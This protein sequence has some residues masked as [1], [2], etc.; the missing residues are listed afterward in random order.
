MKLTSFIA[1]LATGVAVGLLLAPKKGEELRKDLTDKTQDTFNK[2]K[3]MSKED[4]E[5]TLKNTISDLKQ[6]INDFD[7]DEFKEN[8]ANKLNELKIKI[9]DLYN[10]VQE[11][12][13]FNIVKEKASVIARDVTVKFDDIKQKI[14]NKNFND[15]SELDD[16]IDEIDDA[17]NIIIDELKDEE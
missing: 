15:L 4:F 1:T 13:N 7:F 16:E 2:F 5:A 6:V 17:L 12:D 10:Q 3:E 8:S 9:E 14:T 11:N